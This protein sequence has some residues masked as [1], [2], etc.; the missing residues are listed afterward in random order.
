MIKRSVRMQPVV[1]WGGRQVQLC[2]TMRVMWQRRE[3][4]LV[5]LA[6]LL[7]LPEK[8]AI[9]GPLAAA[10][11]TACATAEAV[12]AG[13]AAAWQMLVLLRLEAVLVVLKLEALLGAAALLGFTTRLTSGICRRGMGATRVQLPLGEAAALVLLM[14]LVRQL[15]WGMQ[16]VKVGRRGGPIQWVILQGH[17]SRLAA[18]GGQM[19]VRLGV[20]GAG[21]KTAAG[22]GE[23]RMMMVLRPAAASGMK[24]TLR[25]RRRIAMTTTIWLLRR[26]RCGGLLQVAV[27]SRRRKAVTKR[28]CSDGCWGWVVMSSQIALFSRVLQTRMQEATLWAQP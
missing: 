23:R 25:R 1:V 26:R 24:R 21:A 20:A 5:G 11:V 22:A 7:Q 13:T 9:G 14:W 15:V 18:A 3:G 2:R 28:A 6:R 8:M 19:R 17:C 4:L 10:A 12:T 27:M 16:L